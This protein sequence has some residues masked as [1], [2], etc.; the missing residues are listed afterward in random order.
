MTFFVRWTKL[1]IATYCIFWPFRPR[2]CFG[3]AIPYYVIISPSVE[4]LFPNSS[5]TLDLSGPLGCY[6]DAG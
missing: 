6:R 4:N 3:D 1:I 5:T 2:H